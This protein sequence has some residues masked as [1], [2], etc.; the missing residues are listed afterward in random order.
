MLEPGDEIDIWVIDKRLGAGGMGS[1]YK[2][3]NRNAK[4]IL[5]A[6]KVL[7][8]AGQRA[9][10]AEERFIR[11]A[12]ILY[13][14]D[15]DNIVKVR[16]VRTDF[17]P[18]YLEMEFVQG[19][20][21]ED[22]L[23]RGAIE[24][25]TALDFMEQ[26]AEAI[27]YLHSVGVRHRDLKPANVLV[28]KDDHRIKVVD[29][30]LAM[31][32]NATRITQSGMTFGTVSY[33][34]PEWVSPDKLDPTAWDLYALGVC[35]WEMLTGKVAFP[36]SGQGSARQQAMQVILSKQNHPPLDPGDEYHDDLRAIIA[37]LTLA[38]PNKRPN[39]A[40]KVAKAVA[41]CNRS[42]KRRTGDTIM[43]PKE[44][45]EQITSNAVA[46]LKEERFARGESDTWIMDGKSEVPATERQAEPA[47]P[48]S[49]ADTVL[50]SEPDSLGQ[51]TGDFSTEVTNTASHQSGAGM[52]VGAAA[53]AGFAVFAAIGTIA[54]IAFLVV[55][56]LGGPATREVDVVVS[57]LP[58][59]TPFAVQLGDVVPNSNDGFVFHFDEVP[60]G[61]TTVKWV[62]GEGCDLDVCP[63]DACDAWCGA[64]EQTEVIEEGDNL[65]TV[66]LTL[67]PPSNRKVRL[68]APGVASKHAVDF[69]IEGHE[70][71]QVTDQSAE[72][73]LLPGKY[74]LEAVT[75]T[76]TPEQRGC[77]QT[78]ACNKG[79]SSTVS[80]LVVEWGKG[81]LALDVA[82]SD[83][84][85]GKSGGTSS[86]PPRDTDE[87]PPKDTDSQPPPKDTDEPPPKDTDEPP[88]QGTGDGGGAAAKAV[89]GA[90]YSAWLKNNEAKWGKDAAVGKN[91]ATADYLSGWSGSDPPPGA[92]GQPAVNVSW[93][94]ASA[95]CSG[96]GGLA[97][98]DAE[99]KS[100]GDGHF[101]EYRQADGK[102]AWISSDG[103]QTSTAV[104]MADSNA[105]TGFRCAR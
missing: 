40:K 50:R 4:R 2:C 1:V 39:D 73:E 28:R 56:F 104:R 17:N 81:Q 30:G 65:Q 92:G 84:S 21:L 34:P 78:D 68:L 7:E 11:E 36:V 10:G 43:P 67:D 66:A 74:T 97:S 42:L 14:L 58:A 63:G 90:Q 20:S 38:D 93:Y 53:G 80:D 55:T 62:V 96:R 72:F 19:E 61:R 24:F 15:H 23:Q 79:C 88:P 27:A 102:P 48:R 13:Q 103:S 49:N 5:A 22:M 83:P 9:P 85:A 3:H 44:E 52:V 99:P 94:A 89:T 77:A 12:E 25:E 87:P 18:P 95:Y 51:V 82:A 64:A 91:L 29:F 69:R 35:F 105:M 54:L 31:E 60:T 6:V 41:A 16:N 76:C 100:F 98:L 59:G 71:T 57:G 70:G 8:I 47:N 101:I 32:S 37:A 46:E 26:M 86:P 75:G 45:L 33:A